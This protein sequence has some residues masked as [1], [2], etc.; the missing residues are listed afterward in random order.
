SGAG[1]VLRRVTLPGGDTTNGEAREEVVRRARAARPIAVFGD[2][3][4]ARRPAAHRAGVAGRV[5]TRIVRSVTRVG[6]AGIPVIST[7]R[8][9]RRLVVGRARRSRPGAVLRRIALASRR[10]TDHGR[11]REGV[12]RARRARSVARLVHVARP[13]RGAADRPGVPRRV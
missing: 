4:R 8:T 6:G 3:A 5:L 11:R 2:V 13:R 7:W 1:A 9:R 10:P 12:G